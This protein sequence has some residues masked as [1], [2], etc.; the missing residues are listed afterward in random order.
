[1]TIRTYQ[2]NKPILEAGA[3]VDETALVIGDVHIGQDSSIWPFSVVRGDVNQ[4]RIGQRTNVQDGCVLHVT[5]K[6]PALPEGHALHIGDA[7]T[8][9]HKVV[10]HGCTI[11]DQ[12][13]IGIGAIVLDG[14]HIQ[15]HVVI[16]AGTVVT[17]GKLLESGFL[18]F[19]APV[20][21]IRPLRDEEIAW[22]D[23]SANHYVKLKNN[24]S[25]SR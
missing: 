21:K 13:L 24:H 20:K 1:M 5:H 8:V 3:Y 12:V 4:I 23:Y 6:Y 11:E 16:G 25:Q 17:Q 9:G 14:A 15:K 7:V 19:G 18:Y 2:T 22:L 10:L